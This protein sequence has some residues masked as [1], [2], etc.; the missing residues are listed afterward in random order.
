MIETYT[1]QR[2]LPETILEKYC[3]LETG[4]ATQIASVVDEDAFKD[5][6]DVLGG[7]SLTGQLL[8]TKGGSRGPIPRL[9]DGAFESR[10]WIEARVDLYK[11]AF[12]FPGH[13]SPTVKDDP[14][15]TRANEVL[16]SETYQQGYS[17]DNV[18]DRIALDV[19]WNPKDGNLD[20]D[21]SAYRA[22]HQEG[23]IDAAILIT[24]IQ[25]DTKKLAK[26]IW[27][28]FVERNP[29]LKGKAQPVEYG[30]TT[31]AN[32]EKAR[33]RV[34]RGDLGTCPILVV[35]IGEQTWDG[36]PWDGR[37]VQYF[38]GEGFLALVD[39]FEEIPPDITY[40]IVS[41]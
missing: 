24:R 36:L 25:D 17:V 38:K 29:Q 12:L 30:T 9:I 40:E 21:F 23:L 27:D 10:G 8:L 3:F 34:L 18:K 35:G 28:E 39:S 5:V 16:I 20:R 19:E 2:V 13:N 31:T 22:W 4:S 6:I 7:F 37:K 14:L 1:Y 11:R 41:I 33:E 26:Q 32:F 15:G